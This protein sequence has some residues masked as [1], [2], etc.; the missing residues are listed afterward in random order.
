MKNENLKELREIAFEITIDP[1]NALHAATAEDVVKVLSAYI[2]SYKSFLTIKL[3]SENKSEEE[4]TE[5][6]KES[7]LIVVDTDFNSFHSSLAPFNPH[8]HS[9]LSVFNDYKSEILDADVDSYTDL[10]NLRNE[11]TKEQLHLIYSPIFSVINRN[12][13]L[14]I[15][16]ENKGERKVKKPIKEFETYFKNTKEKIVKENQDKL[17]Q[18]FVQTPDINSFSKKDIIYSSVLEHKTYPYTTDR[19]IFSNKIIYLHDNITCNVEY[20]DDLYFISYGELNIQV[21]GETREEAEEAFHFTFYSL[22]IN[23]AE[24]N[25]ENLTNDAILLK[26]KLTT[27]IRK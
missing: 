13:S 23:Y 19:I 26:N 16:T 7:K 1:N 2:S 5:T 3:H 17:F 14:K 22:V 15:K 8:D 10:R 21:W 9:V 11:F 12:Y 18:F 24:D 27:M 25:D 20:I 6:L 4:I